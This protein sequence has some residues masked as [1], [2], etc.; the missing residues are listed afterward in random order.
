MENMLIIWVSIFVLTLIVEFITP[1]NL[2]TIWFSFGSLGGIVASLFNLD[3][4]M[5]L[6]LF[7]LLTI[8]SFIMMRPLAKQFLQGETVATNFDRIIGSQFTLMMDLAPNQVCQQKVNEAVWS[9]KSTH[10]HTIPAGT[11]VQV[12]SIDG[13][14]LMVRPITKSN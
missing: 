9:I 4:S 1:L 2:I 8:T 10:P 5:Q 11:M 12:L 14:K 13:V 7:V 3:F 6:V